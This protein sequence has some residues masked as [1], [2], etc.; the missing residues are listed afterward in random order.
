MCV[1]V[2]TRSTLIRGTREEVAESKRV[3]KLTMAKKIPRPAPMINARKV[4]CG[5][6]INVRLAA[7]DHRMHAHVHV[8]TGQI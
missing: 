2:A 7:M 5:K 1:Y 4:I 6:S 3:W 8:G